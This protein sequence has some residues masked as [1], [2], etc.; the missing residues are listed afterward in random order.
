MTFW[1]RKKITINLKPKRR[2][3]VRD[4]MHVT[5]Q[6]GIFCALVVMTMCTYYFYRI[7]QDIGIPVS[8]STITASNT[9]QDIV[10]EV[11]RLMFLPGGEVPTIATINNDDLGRAEPMFSNVEKGDKVLIYCEYNQTILYSSSRKKIINV[12]AEVPASICKKP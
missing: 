11:G 1:K 4:G 12:I 8:T 2:W 6:L 7:S 9:A 10:G 3:R 5:V